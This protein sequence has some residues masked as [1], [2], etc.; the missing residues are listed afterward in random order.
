MRKLSQCGGKGSSR[1]AMMVTYVNAGLLAPWP[2]F[3][4]IFKTSK[5]SKKL[6]ED[7]T[8][9]CVVLARS[10]HWFAT[11]SDNKS[12][13]FKIMLRFIRSTRLVSMALVAAAVL[14][15]LSAFAPTSAQAGGYGYGGY[16]HS[17]FGP[18]PGYGGGFGG[19]HGGGYGGY[20]R[21]WGGG[22][23]GFRG[24]GHSH[25]GYGGYGGYGRG[26]GGYGRGYGGW[27]R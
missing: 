21:S 27:C 6:S 20:N 10:E 2:L 3:Q 16:G 23:G 11:Q 19:G 5:I 13:R 25:G 9:R 18:R 17:H 1:G 12:E 14:A 24:Y 22:Y 4:L 26:F 15:G 7:R 8:P